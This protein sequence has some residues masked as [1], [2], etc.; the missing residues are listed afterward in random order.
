MNSAEGQKKGIRYAPLE[1]GRALAPPYRGL[2]PLRLGFGC[3]H[4]PNVSTH[5]RNMGFL[6]PYENWQ[7]TFCLA[8]HKPRNCLMYAGS[9]TLP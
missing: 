4:V 5:G 7:L 8:L 2:T 6:Y 1:F 9:K 3:W